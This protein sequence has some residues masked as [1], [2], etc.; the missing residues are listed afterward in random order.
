MTDRRV[1]CK[2]GWFFEERALYERRVADR[3][4]EPEASI[5][6]SGDTERGEGENRK[7]KSER[8]ERGAAAGD[9]QKK[10]KTGSWQG[11]EKG[12]PLNYLIPGKKE[13]RV[14]ELGVRLGSTTLR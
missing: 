14:F 2:P 11:R 13:F 3:S 6:R 10:T 8:K 4:A 1:D 5:T 7:R 12:N 9:Q